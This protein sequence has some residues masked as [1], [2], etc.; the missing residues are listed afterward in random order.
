MAAKKAQ[1]G[2]PTGGHSSVTS[3]PTTER[4]LHT[5]LNNPIVV[6]QPIPPGS[7]EG[8]VPANIL[9][10][11][12]SSASMKTKLIAGDGIENPLDI[13]EDSDG[14]LIVGEK[15]RGFIKILTASKT[16][17]RTFAD[18]NRNF[19]GSA[20]DTCTLDGTNNSIVKKLNDLGLATNVS[21][22]SGDVIYGADSGTTNGKIVGINTSGE[23]VEV[24]TWAELGNF[25]PVAMEVRTIGGEDHLFA[26]GRWWQGGWRSRFYTKN[27]TTGVGRNCDVDGGDLKS[28]VQISNDLTVNNSGSFIYYIIMPI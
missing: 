13:V 2:G 3:K 27:L 23:C 24:I 21:G 14:N 19:R 4:F 7:G 18:N 17:D 20:T 15:R 8:D 11:L 1:E 22:V 5:A 9:I 12:D 16:V 28:I 6:S 25:R 26:S 10:L